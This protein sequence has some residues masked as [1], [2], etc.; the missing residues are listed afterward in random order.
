M[1]IKSIYACL[2]C[3][4]ALFGATACN[5]GAGAGK[6]VHELSGASTSDSISNL[7]GQLY[8]DDYWQMSRTDS[9]VY[10]GDNAKAQYRR[11]VE[12]GL[13]LAS[14]DDAFLSGLLTGVDIVRFS[15]D[16]LEKNFDVK[17][18]AKQLLDGLDYGLQSDSAVN[19]QEVQ[20]LLNEI[21]KRLDVEK[22]KKDRAL[23]D[24]TL[25]AYGKANNLGTP[26]DGRF[27]QIARKGEG[28]Q[29]TDGQ[30]VGA[31]V[32]VRTAEGQPIPLQ[33][34]KALTVGRDFNGIPVGSILA[35]MH[36]DEV[37]EITTTA[38]DFLGKRYARYG[39]EPQQVI[40]VTVAVKGV[41]A[42][43]AAAAE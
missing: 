9:A 43:N 10:A 25:A 37:L 17:V 11:G 8:A 18:V 41:I 29:F 5:G 38:L 32:S 4:A 19:L 16:K 42:D 23:A 1:K 26:A 30:M 35:T 6:T 36:P 40:I 2:L 28:A 13:A 21:Q 15:K 3:G 27:V 24:S 22:A 12:R 39:L 20:H 7:L 33:L 34:P 14:E 31:A